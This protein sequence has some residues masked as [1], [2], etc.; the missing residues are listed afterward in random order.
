MKITEILVAEHVVFHNLFD[1]IEKTLPRLKTLAEVKSLAATLDALMRPHA[2]TEDDLLMGQ[3]EHCLE[4]LGQ[5]ETFHEEHEEIDAQLAEV[6]KARG[7]K[8]ARDLLLRAVLRSREHFDK[9]E[10]L[11]FPLAERVLK[12]KTLSDLGKQWMKRREAKLK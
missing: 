9:E 4:Q 12:A 7:P 3:L 10:R 8:Q 1:H 6:Q 2:G 5:S 11:V